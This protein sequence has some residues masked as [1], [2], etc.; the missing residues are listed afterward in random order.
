M[1]P[2]APKPTLQRERIVEDAKLRLEGER[3]LLLDASHEL[4][5][6][7]EEAAELGVRNAWHTAGHERAEP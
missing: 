3:L 7:E 6:Q 4:S 5:I 2:P 1:K